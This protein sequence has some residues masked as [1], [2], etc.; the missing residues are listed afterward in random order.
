MFIQKFELSMVGS[1]LF[2]G[3]K[4]IDIRQYSVCSASM[5]GVDL[6]E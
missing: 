5:D 4:G 2:V 6:K 3:K 1:L